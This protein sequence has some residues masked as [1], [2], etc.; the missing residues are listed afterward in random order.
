MLSSSACLLCLASSRRKMI[1]AQ[2]NPASVT[3]Q[4]NQVGDKE[5]MRATKVCHTQLHNQSAP[6]P[7]LNLVIAYKL[8]RL[9]FVV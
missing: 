4:A 6:Q 7:Y 8:S 5:R 9:H 3:V 1:T 2:I